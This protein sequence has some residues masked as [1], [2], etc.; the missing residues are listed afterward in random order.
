MLK[1]RNAG[2]LSVA[3]EDHGSSDG[4]PAVLLHGFPYDVM[5]TTRLCSL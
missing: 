5:A 3:F 1:Y 2:N 4:W